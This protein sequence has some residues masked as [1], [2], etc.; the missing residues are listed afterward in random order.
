M[1]GK[2]EINMN[3]C[4]CNIPRYPISKPDIMPFMTLSDR[5][6]E[7]PGKDG[8]TPRQLIKA[9]GLPI[10]KYD[11]KLKIAM[12]EAFGNET[13]GDD[14]DVF[15]DFF[16]IRKNTVNIHFPSGRN[17]KSNDEWIAESSLDVQWVNALC[18][19]QELH[20]VFSYDGSFERMYEAVRYASEEIRAD[21]VLMCFGT[22]EFLSQGEISAYFKNSGSVF[23]SAAGDT[24]GN[25]FFPASSS[26]VISVGGSTCE[27]SADGRM[28]TRQRAWRYGGGGKSRYEQIPYFQKVFSPIESMSEGFRALPDV[29]FY[30]ETNPGAFVYISKPSYDRD[31]TG[32]W[33][34]SGGTSLA[35]SCMCALCAHILLSEPLGLEKNR[36]LPY[37]YAC[38]GAS[39]YND[40]QYCFDD[41]KTGSNGK[42]SAKIGWDFCTGL[43][44]PVARQLILG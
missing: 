21:I 10:K 18:P 40:P 29:C 6:Y 31:V 34:T 17:A 20:A 1:Q 38:A 22:G 4:E 42:Y 7:T 28:I 26:G 32:G 37:M 43:G 23:V 14:L 44:S 3:I 11:K 9:Y 41:V 36:L 8:I 12:I 19:E 30:A 15:C 24:G 33:T 39:F 5:F 2:E 16:G 27:M 13:L 35:A 25:V